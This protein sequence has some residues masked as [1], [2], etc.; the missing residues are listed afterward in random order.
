MIQGGTLIFSDGTTMPFSQLT[1]LNTG[2]NSGGANGLWYFSVGMIPS[3]G[4]GIYYLSQTAPTSNDLAAFY[5]DG[6]I[7]VAFNLSMTVQD[8]SL[9]QYGI[10]THLRRPLA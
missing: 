4:T 8:A 9:I 10:N 5:A 7:P 2:S 3:T 1:L 6:V